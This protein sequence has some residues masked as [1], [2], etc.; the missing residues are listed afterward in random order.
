[1][2][3]VEATVLMQRI[4]WELQSARGRRARFVAQQP[5]VGAAA[6][7]VACPRC[8]RPPAALV[9][10]RHEHCA[11]DVCSWRCSVCA[12]DFCADHGIAQCR[13]DEQP[14][15]EEHAR[16]CKS[17]GMPHCTAHEGVCAE[18]EHPACSACLASCGSC[19]RIVC[20]LHARQ[21]RPTRPRAAAGCALPACATARA[22]PTSRSAWTRS[23]RARAAP[24]R[25]A[26]RTRGRAC[27]TQTCTARST[28][29]APTGHAGSCANATAHSA[30][31]SPR[32][33]SE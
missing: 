7:T 6:W 11:C 15:C 10:C 32:P 24:S 13:V 27:W 28:C 20:N 18:G 14:A 23:R 3:L 31:T 21:S 22:T 5:L 19:G 25:C 1:L 16:V 12:E 33:R 29:A 30:R 2:Q 26:P 17:C 8:G 4:E 9:V